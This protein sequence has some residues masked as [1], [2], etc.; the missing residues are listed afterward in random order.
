MTVVLYCFH[1][2]HATVADFDN[3]FQLPEDLVALVGFRKVL[4]DECFADVSLD[5]FTEG[6]VEQNDLS[7][8][9]WGNLMMG[10]LR[11][12]GN[13]VSATDFRLVSFSCKSRDSVMKI[14][15]LFLP[16]AFLVFVFNCF[17]K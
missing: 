7:F 12:W 13:W 4:L 9:L 6:R 2:T 5:D 11:A 17:G 3:E 10:M 1:V 15:G 16:F 8:Y 14:G